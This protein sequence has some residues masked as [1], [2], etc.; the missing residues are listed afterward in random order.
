MTIN[1]TI[2]NFFFQSEILQDFFFKFQYTVS[3]KVV[4]DDNNPLENAKITI[5]TEE[6]GN[7]VDTLTTSSNG[8]VQ[9][10]D[11][12]PFATSYPIV[13]VTLDG[14]QL[15]PESVVKDGITVSA[16]EPNEFEIKM[17]IQSV[18]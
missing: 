15:D 4:D 16:E 18:S 14:Y 7:A 13:E 8:Q 3:F 2:E 1:C 5:K 11:K 10:S 17:N 9:M 12:Q 6:N